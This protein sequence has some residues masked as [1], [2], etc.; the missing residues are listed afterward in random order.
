MRTLVASLL[1]T[2][3]LAAPAIAAPATEPIGEITFV[4]D[5]GPL[6]PRYLRTLGLAVGDRPTPEALDAAATRLRATYPTLSTV[7]L[8]RDGPLLA[9]ELE[10]RPL[11]SLALIPLP[12]LFTVAAIG[13]VE[14]V[15]A[16][17]Q[18]WRG[19][20][21]AYYYWDRFTVFD[22]S[23]TTVATMV[24]RKED[25]YGYL[26]GEWGWLLAPDWQL[27]WFAEGYLSAMPLAAASTYD[28]TAA[29]SGPTLTLGP[30][31]RYDG[32]DSEFFPRQG[33]RLRVGL[34]WGTPWWG[35]P[36]D[37]A[38]YRGEVHRYSPLGSQE[39]LVTALRLAF[40]RGNIPWHHK[41]QAGGIYNLRGYDY[42]RFMGDRLVAGTVEY[43]RRLLEDL[44]V[45]GVKQL[46]FTGGAFL[47]VGRAWEA[48]FGVPFPQ[49]VRAGVGG[50]MAL[51]MGTWNVGRLEISYGTEGMVAGLTTG[52]P[53]EW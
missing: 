24:S 3:L 9:L 47:D 13:G 19:K 14:G 38:I 48:R 42:Q 23:Q 52:L 2:S 22:P 28:P 40:G 43:R 20:L 49:D 26:R 30:D 17:G 7:V 18:R 33:T 41:I 10:D 16:L 11:A 15:Q 36:S 51:S 45:L 32:T 31:L 46:A 4:R 5:P 29:F 53:F 34:D 21:G 6:G 35:N 25:D 37:F 27:L 1:L 39:T 12:W 8:R 44:E 50:Y